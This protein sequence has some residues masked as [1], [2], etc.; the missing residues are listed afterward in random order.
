VG[1]SALT[2]LAAVALPTA[3]RAAG[4]GPFAVAPYLQELGSTQVEVRVELEPPAPAK[5]VLTPGAGGTAVEVSAP[6]SAFPTLRATGLTPATRYTYV[7]EVSGA[8][9][10]GEF[11][12]APPDD[13]R[14]PFT[15][16][17][18]GDNRSDRAAHAAVVAAMLRAPADFLLHTGDFVAD[19]GEPSQWRAFFDVE[20]PLLAS[21][22]VFTAVGNHE[23]VEAG[24]A[25]YLRYFGSR[26]P[27]E[28][29]LFNRTMR[30][31]FTRFF[32]V[33]AFQGWRPGGATSSWLSS[34]LAKAENEPGLS[35][36]V[37]VLHHGPYSSGPHGPN[38]LIAPAVVDEW[39][40][41][42]VDLVVAGH[43]HLYE[44]GA[45]RGLRYLVTGGAGAPPYPVE[46]VLPT[47]RKVEP[48]RHFV[49]LRFATDAVRVV[50][51][52]VDGTILEETG[53]AEGRSW[54]DDPPKTAP[55]PPSVAAPPS[56][57]P[58]SACGCAVVGAAEGSAAVV[59]AAGALLL[60]R[61]R[62]RR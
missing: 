48:S 19:G 32:F 52:R 9:A 54:D 62:R 51:R 26:R 35:W 11:V 33:N 47:T 31:Q 57:P 5:L 59:T 37:I 38:P 8:T 25:T 14:T 41:R 58:R 55:A 22:C 34:E 42:K 49:E 43:D 24:A 1:R 7:V 10:R 12:T 17:A 46:H 40:R 44:R 20:A 28:E 61:R 23:L 50:A 15:A 2:I 18:Y 13:A 4:P 36:R 27:G 16:I 29:Q 53:F 39:V 3:A 60:L 45:A 56:P 21:R 6:A 30:W